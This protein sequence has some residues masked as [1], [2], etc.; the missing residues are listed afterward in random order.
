L[1]RTPEELGERGPAV[2]EQDV[3]SPAVQDVEGARRSVYERDR[4]PGDRQW[5]HVVTVI[6]EDPRL[7][8]V[9]P[10]QI[11]AHGVLFGHT[12]G[13]GPKAVALD[14]VDRRHWIGTKL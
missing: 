6:D 2:P 13:S 3:D 10:D 12:V 5:I 9:A 7:G 14:P 4:V 11:V 1:T 8:S